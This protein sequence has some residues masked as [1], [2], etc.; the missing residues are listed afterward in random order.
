MQENTVIQELYDQITDRLQAHDEAG[1]LTAL[2]ARFMELP[3]NLQGEIMVLM[4][5]DA[6]LQRDRAEEAQIKMLE[7]GVAA[8]KAL[9]ALK[10]KLEKGD[11]SVV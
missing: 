2:K 6:V 5:E 7:E 4:L 11:T 9:E 8:I 10:A 3:E 1:A